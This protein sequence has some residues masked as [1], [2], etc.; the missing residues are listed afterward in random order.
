MYSLQLLFTNYGFAGLFLIIC[1]IIFCVFLQ[2]FL[3]LRWCPDVQ[4]IF[5]Q[6]VKHKLIPN[7][8]DFEI[9]YSFF[10]S[11]AVLMTNQL[12]SLAVSSLEE[13]TQLLMPNKSS[14]AKPF[15]HPGFIIRLVL[16]GDQIKFE[17]DF[18]DFNL[19]LLNVFDLMLKAIMS[20]PRVEAKI[21]AELHTE[22]RFL[23]PIVC[24]NII[25]N[26]KAK[27]S[28]VITDQSYGPFEHVKL[29]IKYSSLISRQADAEVADFLSKDHTF[30][31]FVEEVKR[32]N[33]LVKEISYGSVQVKNFLLTSSVTKI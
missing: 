4:N 3:F 6:A 21:Y 24:T 33:E 32:Y 9:A 18:N 20:I 25:N 7:T 31:K 14:F 10:N 12:Q 11:L 28:K 2:I 30:D 17:P 8:E 13:Y 15:S 5:Y 27:V 29:Y 23:E 22:N 26:L 19:I 16:E 1:H